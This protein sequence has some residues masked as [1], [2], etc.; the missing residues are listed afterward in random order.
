[1]HLRSPCLSRIPQ[2]SGGHPVKAQGIPGGP[3][4]FPNTIAGPFEEHIPECSPSR[5]RSS[6]R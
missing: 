2:L 5:P 4:F 3:P 6:N 1:M